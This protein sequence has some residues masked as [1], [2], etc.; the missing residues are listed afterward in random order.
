MSDRAIFNRQYTSF[1]PGSTT[2][3]LVNGGGVTTSPISTFD[4]TAGADLIQGE[5]VYVSGAVVLPASAASGVPLEE[6]QVV[7]LASSAASASATVPVILDDNALVSSANIIHESA[8]T[9]GE[10]YFLA[11]VEGKLVRSNAPSGITL[12]G[13]YS[14]SAL[15]GLAISSSELHVEIA[16]PVT[17]FD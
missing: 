5:V 7:G 16:P 6:Y 11:N 1:Q 9:P 13:G 4:F 3:F 15:V 14:A 17:L 8:L 12:S 10:Y 2:V